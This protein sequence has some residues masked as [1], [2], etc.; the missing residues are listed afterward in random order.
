M[1]RFTQRRCDANFG[2]LIWTLPVTPSLRKATPPITTTRN[3]TARLEVAS[4]D[5]KSHRRSWSRIARLEV[6]LPDL[7]SHRQTWSCIARLEVASPDLKS[8]RQSWNSF[9]VN[10]SGMRLRTASN[11][12]INWLR[13]LGRMGTTFFA[14]RQNVERQNV[15]CQDV[16]RQNVKQQN[17]K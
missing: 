9:S 2:R 8:H 15:K 6:A 16:K 5:L 3:R 1:K 14:E 11:A 7:K 17:V 12:F 10:E 13:L 4:P